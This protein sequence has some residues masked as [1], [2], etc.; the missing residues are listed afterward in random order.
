MI[1]GEGQIGSAAV[2]AFVIVTAE[3]VLPGQ[4]NLLVWHPDVDAKSDNA[5]KRH[6]HGNRVYSQCIVR[7]DQLC[8][9]QIQQHNSFPDIDN[10]HRLVILIKDQHLRIHFPQRWG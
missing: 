1:D 2:L 6:G 3:D 7:F 9:P 4:N 10:T 8:L 5:R